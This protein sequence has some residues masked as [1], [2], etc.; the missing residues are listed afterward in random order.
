MRSSSFDFVQ[1]RVVFCCSISHSY[2]AVRI[3]HFVFRVSYFRWLLFFRRLVLQLT[4]FIFCSSCQ[5]SSFDSIGQFTTPH[6]LLFYFV[7]FDQWKYLVKRR[8]TYFVERILTLT[9]RRRRGRLYKVLYV[10]TYVYS[11]SVS[12]TEAIEPGSSIC[13]AVRMSD[14]LSVCLSICLYVLLSVCLSVFLFVCPYVCLSVSR[15][16]SLSACLSVGRYVCL[17]VCLSVCPSVHIPNFL[18]ICPSL[19]SYLFKLTLSIAPIP[20]QYTPWLIGTSLPDS[21]SKRE[22]IPHLWLIC[23]PGGLWLIYG[24]AP[25]TKQFVPIAERWVQSGHAHLSEL[26]AL[27]DSAA[28]GDV[29]QRT[30][31][32][33]MHPMMTGNL[34][35]SPER[36]RNGNGD[37]D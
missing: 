25:Y 6:T 20:H 13:L 21:H 7:L 2:S 30:W 37:G 16:V 23:W 9:G 31:H 35:A 17:S 1:P 4:L 34:S 14:C 29:G 36:M 8:Y 15:N 33:G 18:S 19:I 11:W 28:S 32:C 3:L 5:R 22:S 26:T 12:H 24:F 27:A 10:Y